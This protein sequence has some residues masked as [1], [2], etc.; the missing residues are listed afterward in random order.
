MLG[1]DIGAVLSALGCSSLSWAGKTAKDAEGHY[2]A[3]SFSANQS[4]NCFITLS[5][6]EFVL[7]EEYSLTA[8]VFAGRNR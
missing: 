8:P 1:V 7:R 2:F 3:L 6:I 4:T 5:G